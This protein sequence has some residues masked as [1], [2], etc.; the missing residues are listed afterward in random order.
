VAATPPR[1]PAA[2][3]AA[4]GQTP[5]APPPPLPRPPAARQLLDALERVA[6]L[7]LAEV[8]PG[9]E[10]HAPL[11]LGGVHGVQDIRCWPEVVV[12]IAEAALE[13]GLDFG[14]ASCR[15]WQRPTRPRAWI[16]RHAGSV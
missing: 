15:R 14:A 8:D 16:R 5:P 7:P 3:Q 12:V 6:N 11:G 4:A 10:P 1:T 13:D 2:G 9:Q